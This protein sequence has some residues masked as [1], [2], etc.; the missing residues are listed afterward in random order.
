MNHPLCSKHKSAINLYGAHLLSLAG[1]V[2]WG[3]LERVHSLAYSYMEVVEV[4]FRIPISTAGY[5]NHFVQERSFHC[6]GGAVFRFFS[7]SPRDTVSSNPCLISIRRLTQQHERQRTQ[8]AAAT[9]SW[10]QVLCPFWNSMAAWLSMRI[11]GGKEGVTSQRHAVATHPFQSIPTFFCSG[12]AET[13]SNTA[14]STSCKWLES[15]VD[16]AS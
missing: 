9:W 4:A 15:N 7:F 6:N 1:V 2:Y 11:W 10:P 5:L 16:R 12:S 8:R 13:L 3:A 14:A